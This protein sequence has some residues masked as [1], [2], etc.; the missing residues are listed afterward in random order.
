MRLNI[1]EIYHLLQQLPLALDI[2]DE[3]IINFDFQI[4]FSTGLAN[5]DLSL[6]VVGTAGADSRYPGIWIN[7]AS[8][9]LKIIFFN[10]SAEYNLGS[11]ALNALYRFE[12]YANQKS[13][14]VSLNGEK[15]IQKD[16]LLS[17]SI[18]YDKRVYLKHPSYDTINGKISNLKIQNSNSYIQP[19]NYLCD[20]NNRFSIMSGVWI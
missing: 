13:L 10:T 1:Y 6:L 16:N 3:I 4:T 19:F 9:Q 20:Y 17:H 11:I 8:K 2:L 5:Q 7:E 18:L 14:S 15:I 12:S